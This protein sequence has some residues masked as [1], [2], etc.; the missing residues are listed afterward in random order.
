MTDITGLLVVV[1]TNSIPVYS[2]PVHKPFPQQPEWIVK[3]LIKKGDFLL[4]LGVDCGK[5]KVWH[6]RTNDIV[7]VSASVYDMETSVV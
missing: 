4:T 6:L 5:V 2:A 1:R 3:D 7:Y